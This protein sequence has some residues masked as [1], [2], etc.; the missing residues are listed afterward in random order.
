MTYFRH[1]ASWSSL[2]A[3]QENVFM[4]ICD[5]EDAGKKDKVYKMLRKEKELLDTF[6]YSVNTGLLMNKGN[7]NKD[8]RATIQDP[9]SNRPIYIGEGLIPQIEAAA[10]K[11][12]YNNKPYLQ[13]FRQIMD[14]L[15]AKS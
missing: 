10:D 11:F 6:M 9:D 2:Y 12:F 4:R 1:D 15:A 7:I 13:L 3:L 14:A 8:G 5:N